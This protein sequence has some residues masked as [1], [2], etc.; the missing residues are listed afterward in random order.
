MWNYEFEIESFSFKFWFYLVLLGGYI[1]Y[2]FWCLWI[3]VLFWEMEIIISIVLR[4]INEIMNI[5]IVCKS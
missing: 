2:V 1:G 3:D 4:E 5:K